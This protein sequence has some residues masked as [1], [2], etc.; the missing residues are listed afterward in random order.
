MLSI[1]Q[2]EEEPLVL[3]SDQ[4][5][6]RESDNFF[7]ILKDENQAAHSMKDNSVGDNSFNKQQL[8]ARTQTENMIVNMK[9][10]LLEKVNRKIELDN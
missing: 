5:S 6:E 9:G 1:N 7:Q 10:K 4:A 3:D 8:V 2:I